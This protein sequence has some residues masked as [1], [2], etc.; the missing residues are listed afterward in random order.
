MVYQKEQLEEALAA[1]ILEGLFK[2]PEENLTVIQIL[3]R[4]GGEEAEQTRRGGDSEREMGRWG[5]VIIFGGG[6]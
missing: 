6:D 4:S 3:Q 5:D 2:D 1:Q